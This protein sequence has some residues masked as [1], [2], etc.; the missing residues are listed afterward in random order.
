VFNLQTRSLFIDIR[1]PIGPARAFIGRHSLSE[2]SIDELR[3]FSQRHA[4]AGYSLVSGPV[5]SSC[6]PVCVR[7]HACDWNFAGSARVRPNK[8]RVLAFSCVLSLR[9]PLLPLRCST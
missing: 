2:L 7:H 5:S 3:L 9:R 6:P 4:F 8:V 1:I